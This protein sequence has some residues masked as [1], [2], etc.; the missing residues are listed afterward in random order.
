MTFVVFHSAYLYGLFVQYEEG[1]LK[2][3]FHV[4]IDYIVLV[5]EDLTLCLCILREMAWVYPQ[6]IWHSLTNPLKLKRFLKIHLRGDSN[7]QPWPSIE[8]LI[9]F[10]WIE[11]QS[12]RRI[13]YFGT[14]AAFT[15][16]K[17]LTCW[18][19]PLTGWIKSIYLQIS[20]TKR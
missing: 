1:F 12:V 11:M 13:P 3:I 5:L 6:L 20:H 14:F 18:P 19:D 15:K 17:P 4:F 7:G 16:H 9:E 2:V 10:P 8:F